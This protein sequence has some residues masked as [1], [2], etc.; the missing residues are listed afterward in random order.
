[1][2]CPVID[3]VLMFHHFRSSLTVFFFQ[4]HKLIDLFRKEA[5]YWQRRRGLEPPPRRFQQVQSWPRSQQTFQNRNHEVC[6]STYLGF[7]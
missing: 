3:V 1:M 4:V 6:E 7:L 2:F 5:K